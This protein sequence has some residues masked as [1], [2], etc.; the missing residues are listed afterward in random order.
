VFVCLEGA[1]KGRERRVDFWNLAA[2]EH[3]VKENNP[4]IVLGFK[5]F[6]QFNTP[7]QLVATAG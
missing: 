7:F 6:S 1:S 5:Q 2:G 4:Q 3:V